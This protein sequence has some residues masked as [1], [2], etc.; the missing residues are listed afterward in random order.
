M[1]SSIRNSLGRASAIGVLA[2]ATMAGFMAPALAAPAAPA[3]VHLTAT[4]PAALPNVNVQGSP[5]KWSPAKLTVKPKSFT[6]CT[7]A[8]EV[9]TISNK[10]KKSQTIS[11]KVGSGKK[12]TLGTLTAGEKAGV[13]A[14]GKAGTKETF[15]LASSK[16]TLTLT[17]S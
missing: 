7:T 17:L 8:K 15:S 11:Y 5:A 4:A 10:T 12:T 13:C 6:E 16:S 2:A 9:W 3:A 1:L 14:Q